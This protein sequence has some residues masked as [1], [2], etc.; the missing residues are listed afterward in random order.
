MDWIHE[1][2]LKTILIFGLLA[3]NLI[4]V[5]LMWWKMPREATPPSAEDPRR[6]SGS[7]ALMKQVLD[8]SD[9]QTRTIDGL[10][11]NR[12]ESAKPAADTLAAL[13][14]R[15]AEELFI[16]PPDT[17]RAVALTAEIGKAQAAVELNRYRSF[18]DILTT[19]SPEQRVAFKPVVVETFG[20]KPPREENLT[21]PGRA[22]DRPA[23]RPAHRPAEQD[24]GK[25]RE[26]PPPRDTAEPTL[27]GGPQDRGNESAPPPDGK[28]G[29]PSAEEKLARYVERLRLTDDQARAV[30][31]ILRDSRDRGRA[32]REMRDPDRAAVDAQKEQIRKDEDDQIM[33]LLT[34]EQKQV[35]SAMRT[36]KPR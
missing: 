27:N 1:N 6:A 30:D 8:L 2:R 36:R 5:T 12:R 25:R 4:M 23:N 19:L 10:I 3:L 20:R 17:A 26:N 32:L 16:D 7:V 35:F 28:S 13:K 18:R 9:T 34:D 21:A 22:K 14:L 33:R 29:P 31:K 24:G 15:L 11:R